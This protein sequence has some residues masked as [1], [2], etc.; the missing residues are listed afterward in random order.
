MYYIVLINFFLLVTGSL[1]VTGVIVRLV[2]WTAAESDRL[3][4]VGQ[5][6]WSAKRCQALSARLM[7]R[8]SLLMEQSAVY[9]SLSH[10]DV[11]VLPSIQRW[12]WCW[13]DCVHRFR[14]GISSVLKSGPVRSFGP[15]WAQPQPDRYY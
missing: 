2:G 3:Y 8:V 11:Y 5:A 6:G 10:W 12:I 13:L 7:A 14:L 15:F 4:S 1:G 9:L